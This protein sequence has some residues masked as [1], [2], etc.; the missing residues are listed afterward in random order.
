M[1]AG[2]P[3][4]RRFGAQETPNYRTLNG[5]GSPSVQ[6]IHVLNWEQ[7]GTVGDKNDLSHSDN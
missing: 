6:A 7:P 5:A 2:A 3:R 1:R 4:D